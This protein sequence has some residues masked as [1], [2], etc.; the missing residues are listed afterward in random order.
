MTQFQDVM[1]SLGAYGFL[2]RTAVAG[3][4]G[5]WTTAGE[6]QIKAMVFVVSGVFVYFAGVDPMGALKLDAVVN[7]PLRPLVN[8]A[9]LAGAAMAEHDVLDFVNKMKNM[10]KKVTN[11]A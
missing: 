3:L 10:A 9:L 2:I 7:S 1:V 11:G 8:V 4:R 5:F 6:K